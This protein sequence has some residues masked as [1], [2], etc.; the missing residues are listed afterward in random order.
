MVRR[1]YQLAWGGTPEIV[2]AAEAGVLM[3]ERSARGVAEALRRLMQ[4]Y[5]DRA[6]THHYAKRFTW[7][8]TTNGQLAM[9]EDIL[10]RKL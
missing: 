5:P 8:E 6:L 3:A 9:F 7:D 2:A 10:R 4:N 1:S